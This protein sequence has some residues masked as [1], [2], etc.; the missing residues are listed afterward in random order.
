M[1]EVQLHVEAICVEIGKLNQILESGVLPHD[2]GMRSP[3][4]RMHEE[5][6][7]MRLPWRSL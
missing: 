1:D 5:M 7:R 2:L 4:E 6:D 3:E